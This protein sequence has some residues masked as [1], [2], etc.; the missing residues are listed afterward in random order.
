[1]QAM[2]IFWLESKADIHRL[3]L[4]LDFGDMRKELFTRKPIPINLFATSIGSRIAL[5]DF[6]LQLTQTH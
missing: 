2:S 1:M 4:S 5:V 3:L 6:G